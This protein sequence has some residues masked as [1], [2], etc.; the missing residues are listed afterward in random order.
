VANLWQFF[1]LPDPEGPPREVGKKAETSPTKTV[2]N[3][4]Q[5]LPLGLDKQVGQESNLRGLTGAIQAAKSGRKGLSPPTPTNWKGP[6]TPDGEPFHDLGEKAWQEL[7]SRTANFPLQAL[8]YIMPD[9]NRYSL[10]LN[11]MATRLNQGD[12]L[13]VDLRSL[14]HMDAHQSACRRTLRQMA[15]EMDLVIF[16]LDDEDKLMMIPGVGVCVDVTK[17]DLGQERALIL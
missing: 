2:S 15:D 5:P 7:T 4:P 10:P 6:I 8:R 3:K 1:G 14:I 17:H 12:S 16:A 11:G 9:E 13:I